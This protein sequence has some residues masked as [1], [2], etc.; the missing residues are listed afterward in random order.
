MP[1]T[2]FWS[3]KWEELQFPFEGK[4]KKLDNVN[5]THGMVSGNQ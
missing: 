5:K 2:N 1:K 3:V 4:G